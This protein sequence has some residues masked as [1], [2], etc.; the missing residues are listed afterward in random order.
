M[1]AHI[2]RWQSGAWGEEATGSELKRL[3]RKKWLV[4]H[5]VAWGDRANHDHVV[6]GDALYL[7]NTKNLADC[8][9]EVEGGALRIRQLDDETQTY[10]A[11]AWIPSLLREAKAFKRKVEAELG[12]PVHVNP[13]LVLWSRFPGEIVY[14]GEVAVV[15]GRHLVEWLEGRP[16]DLVVPEKRRRVAE[17]VEGLRRATDR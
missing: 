13:V 15:Q 6:A 9:I 8:R 2:H 7:L 16:C 5:D 17:M 10:L 11:D 14:V 1:P 4:R 3:S 12:F